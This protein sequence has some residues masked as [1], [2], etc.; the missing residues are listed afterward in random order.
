MNIRQQKWFLWSEIALSWLILITLIYYTYLE[1]VRAPYVGFQYTS[2]AGQF[3]SIYTI[4]DPNP[5]QG[6]QLTKEQTLLKINDVDVKEWSEQLKTHLFP[7]LSKGDVITLVVDDDGEQKT[8]NWVVPGFNMDEFRWRVF[9]SWPLGYLFW[10]AGLATVLLVRPR[11]T[12][13]ALF[14]AFFFLTALWLVIGNTSRW[15]HGDSRLIYRV[16][17][18]LSAPVLLHLHWIF[19]RPLG[20]I[21]RWLGITLYAAAIG[22][23]LLHWT[24]YILPDIAALIF[25]LAL[26]GSLVLLLLHYWRQKET[27]SQVALLLVTLLSAFLPLIAISFVM[28]ARESFDVTVVYGLATLPL[29]PA[30]YFYSIYRFQLGGSEF[31]ANRLIVLYLFLILLSTVVSLLTMALS[32]YTTL[33]NSLVLVGIVFSVATA[34]ISIYGFPPFQRLIERTL[35]AMPLPP[36]ELI[37]TYLARITTTLSEE[38]LS[39]LLQHE[40]LPTL[41]VRESALI[42]VLDNDLA[43]LY[44]SHPGLAP[45]P[46]RQ[47]DFPKT[48]HD[49]SGLLEHFKN[50]PIYR[51]T[52]QEETVAPAWVKVGIALQMGDNLLGFWLLGRRDPDDL[53][54]F[55]E[56][57]TL[58]TLARQTALALAN[59]DQAAQLQALYQANIE[60][61]EQEH[62]K[63]AHFLHDAIL[64]QAVALYNAIPE[65]TPKIQDEYDQLKD[66]IRQMTTTLRPPS[67]LFGL[68][69]AL[70]ELANELSD[71]AKIEIQFA[72][73]AEPQTI[74]Y[75]P[76]TESHIYRIVQQACENAM[77]HAHP[78]IIKIYGKLTPSLVDLTVEDN[79]KGFAIEK[80]LNMAQLLAEKHFGLVHMMERASHIHARLTIDSTPGRGTKVHLYW[81]N[82]AGITGNPSNGTP[83]TLMTGLL[84]H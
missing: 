41:L 78:R 29:I 53:Y 43:T 66:Y 31:R 61:Q 52:N 6:S 47:D 11:D 12:K 48:T 60:R 62:I 37:D 27:R 25:G 70:E 73:T 67:L 50:E 81:I 55:I 45:P 75:A 10:M 63:L 23:A 34:L 64:N 21:P 74:Q 5:N 79:G 22:V 2:Q 15:G 65:P 40:V 71:R 1:I 49:F 30:A 76:Q 4:P 16:I 59:I 38:R 18:V 51:F 8:I 9:N 80:P 84:G 7:P 24:P 33:G 56:V 82:K 39:Q 28:V 68:G 20:K 57:N 3:T 14:I 77:R 13:R 36:V 19:P 54:T 69:V 44:S 26:L 35:L 58:Q 72:V 46:K 32:T 17:L 42:R 83:P